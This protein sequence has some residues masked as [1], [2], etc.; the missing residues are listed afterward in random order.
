LTKVNPPSTFVDFKVRNLKQ[1]N[2]PVD[3]DDAAT[4]VAVSTA[5]FYMLLVMSLAATQVSDRRM[6]RLVHVLTAFQMRS[7]ADM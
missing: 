5:C 2:M 4:L 3:D 7:S 6:F 1:K